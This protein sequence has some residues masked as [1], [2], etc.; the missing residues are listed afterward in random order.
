M[1]RCCERSKVGRRTMCEGSACVQGWVV[2][3]ESDISISMDIKD[4]ENL[5]IPPGMSRYHTPRSNSASSHGDVSLINAP[6]RRLGP[7]LG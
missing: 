2:I 7:V 5:S 6:I 3:N 1:I 4:L